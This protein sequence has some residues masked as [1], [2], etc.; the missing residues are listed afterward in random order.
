MSN[1][2]RF[3]PLIRVST[4]KQA[5][6]GESLRTQ[7]KYILQAV[8]QLGGVIPEHCWVY[9][10]QEHATPDQE[11]EKLGKLLSDAGKG[12]FDAVMVC[13]AS[14]WSRDNLRSKE[15]LEGLVNNDIRFFILQTEF[16]LA[17]PEQSMFLGLATEINEFHAKEQTRKS[18]I[19]RIER[20]KRGHP[21]A[22]K[23]P[24]G[25]TYNKDLGKWG[26]DEEKRDKIVRAA[27]L[28][29][30]GEQLSKVA[31][32][33]GMNHSNLHKILT[34]RSGDKWEQRFRSEKL[35]IDE[36]VITRVPSLL[37]KDKIEKI[38][39]KAD[40]NKTYS[41]GFIK[42]SYMLARMIFCGKC[43]YAMFGQTNHRG[44][45]YY[46]HQRRGKVNC[47][48]NGKYV[49]ADMIENAVIVHLFSKFYDPKGLEQALKDAVLDGS[50][51]K[52]LNKE[53]KSLEKEI[54]KI[55][56]AKRN[57][58][59]MLEKSDLIANDEIFIERMQEHKS[60]V[61]YI[62]NRL[63]NIND[64]LE[65]LP[66]KENIKKVTSSIKSKFSRIK[67]RADLKKNTIA[68]YYRTD[69]RLYEMDTLEKRKF[70]QQFF[71]GKDQDGNRLGVYLNKSKKGKWSFEIRGRLGNIKDTLPLK[72]GMARALL[73]IEDERVNPFTG[74][75]Y[76]MH[77]K[78]HAYNCLG[79]YQ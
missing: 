27:K 14:R 72:E 28:Y 9:S 23:L 69:N 25:R 65:N 13:D 8:K 6:K 51:V 52:E 12:L 29:L 22:G 5:A 30:E 40:A 58:I 75:V 55:N 66:T 4:E 39:K 57:L 26:I 2:I 44:K 41:H 43:G 31:K 19:N 74:E 7:K 61:D 73:D 34:K 3:A 67:M 24:F 78:C 11:R 42:H 21:V 70:L 15:A 18:L 37:P 36:K 79:L 32:M 33:L 45:R 35:N 71:D 63:L 64:K 59:I 16:K 49:P 17:L 38:L 54:V 68:A 76:D 77:S 47:L 1:Q 56:R 60:R 48:H 62:N 10:G 53:K 46:R 20:A 50:K